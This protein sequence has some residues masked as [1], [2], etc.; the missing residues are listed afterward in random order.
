ML[1]V[2]L[3][4]FLLVVVTLTVYLCSVARFN[5]H[6]SR[7][8]EPV[9][10]DDVNDHVTTTHTGVTSLSSSARN[11]EVETGLLQSLLGSG[12]GTNSGGGEAVTWYGSRDVQVGRPANVRYVS[13][14]HCARQ[15]S[16]V[17]SESGVVTTPTS[18]STK[19]LTPL[20]P[21]RFGF[22]G[23][24]RTATPPPSSECLRQQSSGDATTAV[25]EDYWNTPGTSDFRYVS[26]HTHTR[27]HT[28]THTYRERGGER[29]SPTGCEQLAKT[30]H[31]TYS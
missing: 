15:S 8:R 18:Q 26:T 6:V 25:G 20:L 14:R 28:H 19:R 11:K 1:G 17:E 9:S 30:L 3:F 16:S 4:S 2:L 22:V 27:T 12:T 23:W 7:R 5:R 10:S 13:L 24:T 29:E 31:L 21:K